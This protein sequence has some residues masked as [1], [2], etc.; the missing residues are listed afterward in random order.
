MLLITELEGAYINSGAPDITFKWK[1]NRTPQ[2]PPPTT[3]PRP[4]V[5]YIPSLLSTMHDP[6]D[7]FMSPSP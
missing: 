5:C 7:V 2:P 1:K 6:A 3:T 4:C